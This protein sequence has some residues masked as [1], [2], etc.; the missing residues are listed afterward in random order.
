MSVQNDHS[1]MFPL[2]VKASIKHTVDSIRLF[3]VMGANEHDVSL[4][5]T[6]GPTGAMLAF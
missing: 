2:E 5:K 3:Y 1:G 6:R 4:T